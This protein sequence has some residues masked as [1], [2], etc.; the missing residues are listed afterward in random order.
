M[1]EVKVNKVSSRTG[2]AV[3]LGNTSDT[4]TVPSDVTITAAGTV[5]GNFKDIQWQSVITADG[6]TNTTAEAGKGYFIDTSSAAHTINLPASPSTGDTVAVVDAAN[7]FNTNNVTVGRNGSNIESSASDDTIS[8]FGA[9][10]F[11]NWLE[12]S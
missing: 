3:T 1:S 4:L 9:Y 6:S 2:N 12:K 8:A 7:T 5:S 10:K 11:N